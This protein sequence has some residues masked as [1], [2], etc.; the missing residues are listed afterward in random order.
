MRN[1]P[2][3]VK[4]LKEWEKLG[5]FQSKVQS[6]YEK[7]ERPQESSEDVVDKTVCFAEDDV[8]RKPTEDNTSY[9][10]TRKV[11]GGTKDNKYRLIAENTSDLIALT[12]FKLNPTYTYVNPSHKKVLGYEPEDMIGKRSFEFIHPDDKKAFMP[13]LKKHVSVKAKKLLTGKSLD[14]SETI[15]YRIKDKSGNWHY[16]KTTANIVGNE[17]LFVSK[18]ATKQKQTIEKLRESEKK[19]HTILTNSLDIVLYQL[20][21]KTGSYDYMSP[22]SKKIFGYSPYEIMS[23]GFEKVG[24]LAHPE[25]RD[26]V[27]EHFDKLVAHAV[28]EGMT[29]TIEYRVKHRKLGYR[30]VSDTRSVIFDDKNV[31]VAMVG[32]IL[33]I[34]KQKKAREVIKNKN[35]EL[36]KAHEKL[37]MLNGELEQRVADRTVKI[38][39]LLKQKDEFINQLGHDLKNPLGPLINL[40]PM[41]GE[42]LDDADSKEIF[43]VLMRNV[44]HMKNLVIK[45]I[46]LAKLN[47]PGTKLTLKNTTLRDEINDLIEKDNLLFKE[48]NIYV[49][50]NVGENIIVQVDKLRFTELFDNLISNAIKYSPGGG[51]ITIDVKEDK[52]FITVSVRDTGMGM[53]KEQIGRIFDEFYKADQ[54]RHDFESSGL[55]MPICKRIIEK[56]GGRI[57][58][59]S[60]GIGKGAT[61]FFTI[62]SYL[63]KVVEVGSDGKNILTGI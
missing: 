17:L 11:L 51:T 21:L 19:F 7:S 2:D 18:D 32:S 47:A 35:V 42:K 57:W 20:D 63:E 9:R 40:L 24:F 34:T 36:K 53:T 13:L 3:I 55:G 44:T 30:W 58:V 12:T 62:P 4:T 46:K 23:F 27:R 26:R 59:E 25:D 33:D 43:E 56:H 8:E 52:N 10:R 37:Q 29:P 41:I 38:E 6:T 14:V 5:R 50:N 48:N 61:V 22:A 60:P 54:A 31:P 45:T 1:E 16:L 28:E 39:K 15:E 49:E